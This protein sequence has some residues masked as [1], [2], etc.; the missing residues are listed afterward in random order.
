[1]QPVVGQLQ[2]AAASCKWWLEHPP[3]A[4]RLQVSAHVGDV[5]HHTPS[6]YQVWSSYI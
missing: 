1:M 5:G 4:L 3:R 2:Y 6:V